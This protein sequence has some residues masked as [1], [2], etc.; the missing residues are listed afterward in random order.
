L[1]QCERK[2][3]HGDFPRRELWRARLQPFERGRA[4]QARDYPL[5]Q[6]G[7][8]LIATTFVVVNLAVAL[9]PALP[10]CER[11]VVATLTDW[12]GSAG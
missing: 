12:S 4:I 2:K 5:V 11:I 1:R 7:V 8:L 10:R 9:V 3:R 6:G